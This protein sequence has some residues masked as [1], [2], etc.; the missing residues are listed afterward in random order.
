MPSLGEVATVV[1]WESMEV[2]GIEVGSI[3]V[4]RREMTD[5]RRQEVSPYSQFTVQYPRFT[6]HSLL[7]PSLIVPLLGAHHFPLKLVP[8]TSRAS[9][10][11][12]RSSALA[13]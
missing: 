11:R 13:L 8:Y 5:C 6:R 10:S 3:E 9:F 2:G 7:L 1:D 4:I 12:I